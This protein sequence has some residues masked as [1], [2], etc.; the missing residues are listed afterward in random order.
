[1]TRRSDT[2]NYGEFS[3]NGWADKRQPLVGWVVASRGGAGASA[4][5][6]AGDAGERLR[7]ADGT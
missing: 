3:R 2:M 1:M 7:V 6:L 4:G 5:H